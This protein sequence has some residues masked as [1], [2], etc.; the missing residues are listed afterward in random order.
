[1][2]HQRHLRTLPQVSTIVELLKSVKNIIHPNRSDH[3]AP[4]AG[5]H[6]HDP[7]KFDLDKRTESQG[8]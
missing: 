2:R 3:H 5:N 4:F 1:M 7:V 6:L 8:T